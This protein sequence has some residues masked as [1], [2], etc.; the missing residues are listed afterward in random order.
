MFPKILNLCSDSCSFVSLFHHRSFSLFCQLRCYPFQ[1]C[2][3]NSYIIVSNWF[4]WSI[5]PNFK[6]EVSFLQQCY[7]LLKHFTYL[8]HTSK[9]L[10]RHFA[11]HVLD[12]TSTLP[13]CK[14]SHVRVY[15]SVITGHT[16]SL[17]RVKNQGKAPLFPFIKE[18][19]D[20]VYCTKKRITVKTALW[21]MC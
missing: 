4:I 9:M 20:T 1:N 5:L 13:A 17:V 19:T 18:V 6:L 16:A 15:R 7:F 11:S 10:C 14:I 2:I 8:S 3:T 12:S 21:S